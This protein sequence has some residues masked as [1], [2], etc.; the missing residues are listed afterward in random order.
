MIKKVLCFL[1]FYF[2]RFLCKC[3]DIYNLTKYLFIGINILMLIILL[4]IVILLLLFCQNFDFLI[5]SNN[6]FNEDYFGITLNESDDSTGK[7][8]Y[9]R[10]L[11][12]PR[13]IHSGYTSEQVVNRLL[14][15]Y[16]EKNAIV[17]WKWK[18]CLDDIYESRQISNEIISGIRYDSNN[19]IYYLI[20]KN[21]GIIKVVYDSQ[22]ESYF[23]EYKEIQYGS[24]LDIKIRDMLRKSGSVS[25]I[26]RSARFRTQINDLEQVSI[27][28]SIFK[29]DEPYSKEQFDQLRESLDSL[30]NPD[31]IFK[32]TTSAE[33]FRFSDNI[34]LKGKTNII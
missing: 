11:D 25:E 30:K 22:A 21:D 12:R 9:Y 24:D 32:P 18:G 17:T 4:I 34:I 1:R 29:D 10:G 31:W 33:S 23:P 27:C 5:F 3:L 2:S 13:I 26:A 19:N 16:W 7:S 14:N 6:L 28:L 8:C 15:E 20:T